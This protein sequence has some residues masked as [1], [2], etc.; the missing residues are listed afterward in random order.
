MRIGLTIS[1]LFLPVQALAGMSCEQIINRTDMVQAGMFQRSGDSLGLINSFPLFASGDKLA[2]AACPVVDEETSPCSA[3]ILERQG[4]TLK[5]AATVPLAGCGPADE[6]SADCPDFTAEGFT[7]GN[8]ASLSDAV[9]RS[10]AAICS[11]FEG[12]PVAALSPISGPQPGP[13]GFQEGSLY[14]LFADCDA[15]AP[16]VA[17][18]CRADLRLL[19]DGDGVMTLRAADTA[20]TC[21]VAEDGM[22]IE[23]L[24]H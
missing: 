21:T 2:Y 11:W 17:L 5:Q 7:A 8:A 1:L 3:I 19:R 9:K 6:W 4:Q 24:S 13:S 18:Q 20:F 22:L 15:A 23:C 10:Q 12:Q 14:E 16:D